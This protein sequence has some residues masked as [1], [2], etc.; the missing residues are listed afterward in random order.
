VI[1]GPVLDADDVEDLAD[2]PENE[3][4]ATTGCSGRSAAARR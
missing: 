2:A 1:A 3:V 4:E